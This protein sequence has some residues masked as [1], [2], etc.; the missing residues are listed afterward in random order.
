MNTVCFDRTMFVMVVIT[1]AIL[2]AFQ[3]FA[4][5]QMKQESGQCPQATCPETTCPV[6]PQQVVT[7]PAVVT[8]T[9]PTTYPHNRD[10]VRD[11]DLSK[12][13]DPLE[14][15]T[16]RVPRHEIPPTGVKRWLDIPTRGYPDNFTQIGLLVTTDESDPDNKILRLFGRQEFPGSNRYEYYTMINS[17]HDQIKVP[18]DLKRKELYDGDTVQVREL[19]QQ[20]TVQMHDYAGPKYYPDIIY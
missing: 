5:Q 16:R 13:Y 4:Y 14:Q 11:Y 1:V 17:G 19:S 2:S 3:F 20:Y 15:P 10:I 9:H 7:P 8:P 12:A 6:C 18:L